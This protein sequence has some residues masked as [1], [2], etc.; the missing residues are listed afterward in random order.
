MEIVVTGRTGKLGGALVRA[1]S[2]E[3]TIHALGRKDADLRHPQRLRAQLESFRFD[4]LVNC[5]A[6]AGLED[7][8]AHPEAARMI[9]A[10]SPGVLADL[11]R[12]RGARLVH[13]STDYVLDGKEAGLKD[14]KAPVNPLSAYARSK[15][16][17]EERA[18]ENDGRALVCRVSWIFG[19]EPPGFIESFLARARAGEDLEAIAD[20]F[21]KP[22]C[23]REI[24]RMVLALLARQDL[25]GVFHLTH[26]GEAESWW[27]CGS[28]ML[29]LAQ[30]LGLLEKV[31][32]VRKRRL[33]EIPAMAASRPHHSAM[34]PTRLRTEL[35]WTGT[36]WE[37]AARQRL[38]V[39]LDK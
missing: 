16:A 31:K 1:W 19:T 25:T 9:N 26:E 15:L 17:G 29:V 6:M 5:A 36:S 14:E 33:E 22:T 34:D 20:K 11:C 12:E 32:E 2:A 24:G 35:G 39:L 4:A 30:E 23:A 18:R 28:R 3:H 7:C 21:S 8:E 38:Q 37:E 10:E 13:F 27:S